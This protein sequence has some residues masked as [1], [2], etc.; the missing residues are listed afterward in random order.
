MTS[1]REEYMARD[2]DG[3][4]IN[5]GFSHKVKAWWF[6][7][8]SARQKTRKATGVYKVEE[9]FETQDRPSYHWTSLAIRYPF[10]IARRH[11]A[12]V[13]IGLIVG[14]G[15]GVAVLYI[16]QTWLGTCGTP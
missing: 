11:T 12:A 2:S 4:R 16:G 8:E 14:I 13:I 3:E 10:V 6:G 1:A 9:G 7:G 15:S 5:Y